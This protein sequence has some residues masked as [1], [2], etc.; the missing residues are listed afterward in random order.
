M[1]DVDG[2]GSVVTPHKA[3]VVAVNM[4]LAR[5]GGSK[6][7]DVDT[8]DG[9]VPVAVVDVVE[10]NGAQGTVVGDGLFGMQGGRVGG[11]GRV[12]V[13]RGERKSSAWIWTGSQ[14]RLRMVRSSG[15]KAVDVGPWTPWAGAQQRLAYTTTAPRPRA[16]NHLRG[17][18]IPPP[19]FPV[20]PSLRPS[21]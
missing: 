11:G 18:A 2:K 1:V 9:A 4:P 5:Q 16:Q 6:V 8:V 17:L 14:T 20:R 3:V 15:A 12:W 10:D 19:P 21:G 13:F 7:V